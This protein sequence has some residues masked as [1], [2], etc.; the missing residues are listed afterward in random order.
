M[1]ELND[2]RIGT[3]FR[4]TWSREGSGLAVGQIVKVNRYY[5]GV[6]KGFRRPRVAMGYVINHRLGYD[7]YVINSND[8]MIAELKRITNARGCHVMGMNMPMQKGKYDARRMRR[9]ARNALK[10]KNNGDNFY[11][12]YNGI[13]RNAGK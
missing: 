11:K 5:H 12:T 3:K 1:V 13:A 7:N 9:L 2:I 10:F 4:V 6:Q 8:G